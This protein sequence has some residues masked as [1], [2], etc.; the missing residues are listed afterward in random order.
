MPPASIMRFVRKVMRANA[1]WWR[2]WL[3][4]GEKPAKPHRP[5]LPENLAQACRHPCYPPSRPDDRR[6][7][8]TARPHHDPVSGGH[9]LRQISLAFRAALMADESTQLRQWIEAAKHC[10]FGAWSASPTA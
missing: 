4:V 3:R 7:T 2:G 5:T 6:A 10:E 1:P 8:A 9:D